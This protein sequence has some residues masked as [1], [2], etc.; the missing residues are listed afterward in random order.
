MHFGRVDTS[1]S[2]IGYLNL[3]TAKFD[4]SFHE[5]VFITALVGA[6][7]ARS[8]HWVTLSGVQKRKKC[9][10]GALLTELAIDLLVSLGTCTAHKYG[11]KA[12]TRV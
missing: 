2:E 6:S 7:S 9:S 4:E 5:V 3:T 11:G 8:L 12:L 1:T 10:L